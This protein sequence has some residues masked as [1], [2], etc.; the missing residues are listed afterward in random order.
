MPRRP[1]A[2][3]GKF[4]YHALNRAVGRATLFECERDY[5]A[6]V[7]VLDQAVERTG[8]RLL[9]WCAMPNHWHLLLWPRRDGE[10]SEFM[11]WLTVTP[12]QR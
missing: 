8:T 3:T 10:L 11:R 2:S 9:G 12:T 7:R 5:A 1:R 6:F 4:V